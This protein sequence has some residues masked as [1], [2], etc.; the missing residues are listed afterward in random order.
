MTIAA[1]RFNQA[2]IAHPEVVRRGVI[3]KLNTSTQAPR[4]SG[5]PV[6]II[7]DAS[8]SDSQDHHE[9]ETGVLSMLAETVSSTDLAPQPGQVGTHPPTRAIVDRVD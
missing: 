5:W 2:A 9:M 7:E 4:D 3:G 6:K 1:A 8:A